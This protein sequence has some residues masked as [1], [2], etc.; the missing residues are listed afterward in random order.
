ML[1]MQT[2]RGF[3]VESVMIGKGGVIMA[4]LEHRRF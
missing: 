2:T 4:N 3:G 1:Q